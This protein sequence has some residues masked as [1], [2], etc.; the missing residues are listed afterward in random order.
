MKWRYRILIVLALLPAQ[1]LFLEYFRFK[2][3]KPDLALIL[4][5]LFGLVYGKGTGLLWGLTFGTILDLFSVGV[6]GANFVLKTSIGYVAGTLGR[7]LAHLTF[8]ANAAILLGISILH[9]I[10]GTILLDGV[11]SE[12]ISGL[13]SLTRS[14]ILPRAIYNS[15][16]AAL[17]FL[18]FVEK[19][20]IKG[21]LEHAGVL[22]PTR[23]NSR[24]T[25]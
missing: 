8:L 4:I 20:N 24:F 15:L 12:G 14:V 1:T 11:G 16:L 23:G 18:I 2:G 17:F 7:S 3:V 13:L 9:D 10:I 22:F 25:E 21:S 19:I 6:L 5:Y